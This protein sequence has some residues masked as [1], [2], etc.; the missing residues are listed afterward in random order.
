[1]KN[2]TVTVSELYTDDEDNEVVDVTARGGINVSEHTTADEAITTINDALEN[3]STE[4][5]KLGA[6]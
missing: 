2:G 6:M 3:V 1:V 4:R 5:S